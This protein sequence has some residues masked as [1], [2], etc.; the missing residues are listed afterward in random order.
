MEVQ[1]GRGKVAVPVSVGVWLGA[2]V[3][4]WLGV[5]VGVKDGWAVETVKVKVGDGVIFGTTGGEIV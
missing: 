1:V 2:K 3:V 5:G 4:V